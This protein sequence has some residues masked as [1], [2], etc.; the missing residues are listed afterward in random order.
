MNAAGFRAVQRRRCFGPQP[1]SPT[2]A[3]LLL[4]GLAG[5][6]P[7]AGA[8]PPLRLID[9]FTHVWRYDDSGHELG[10]AWR[11]SAYN[12]SSWPTGMG[13]FGVET[14][15]PFHYA[16]AGFPAVTVP[17]ALTAPGNTAQT[18]TFYFRT[19]FQVPS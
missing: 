19:H 17:L 10:T 9:P 11:E 13:L 12:D 14:T 4:A 2:A 1:L 3:V 7:W 6:T 5:S 15:T 8:Q 16:P 18:V